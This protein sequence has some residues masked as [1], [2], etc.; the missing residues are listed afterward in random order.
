MMPRAEYVE[1]APART[2]NSGPKCSCTRRMSSSRSAR[3]KSRSM[4]GSMPMSSEM[5]RSSVRFQR[6]GSTWLMPIR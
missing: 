5:N 3:G 2:A 1:T 4:S 6:R